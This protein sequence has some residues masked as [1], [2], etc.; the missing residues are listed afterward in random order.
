MLL[1][2]LFFVCVSILICIFFYKQANTEFQINQIET[3]EKLPKLLH[4][5]NPIVIQP[6]QAPKELWTHSDIYER[7]SLG[8]IV[9]PNLNITIQ[10]AIQE[11]GKTIPWSSDF[12]SNVANITGIPVWASQTFTNLFQGQ[13]LLTK[14]YS[15]DTEVYLGPQGLQKTF[16]IATILFA[17][18]G[19]ATVTILNEQSNPYL[20]PGWKGKRL[21]LMTR[22]DAP[23]ISQIEC[24]DI[25]VRPGSALLLPPHWKY[26]VEEG[27]SESKTPLCFVK[28]VIHHPI[29]RLM[30]RVDA[31]KN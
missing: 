19:I 4:E 9:I 7:Q 8:S 11:Q 18:E 2:I 26:C 25:V 28:F 24:M 14:L 6:F 22:D 15:Y 29:S 20:P 30:A 12:A 5:R 3:L 27:S 23:L 10:Q 16:G 21:S 1:E 31:K 17:T 13:G